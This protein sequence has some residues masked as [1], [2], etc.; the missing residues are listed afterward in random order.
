VVPLSRQ[1]LEHVVM[2]FELMGKLGVFK[3]EMSQDQSWHGSG[4]FWPRS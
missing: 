4:Y 2:L 3:F 1:D